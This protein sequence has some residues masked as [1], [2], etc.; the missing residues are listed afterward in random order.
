MTENKRAAACRNFAIRQGVGK[1][2]AFIDQ[3]DV[4]VKD[5]LKR[6]IDFINE[7]DYDAVHGNVNYIDRNGNNIMREECEQENESRRKIDWANLAKEELARRLLITPNIRIISSLIKREAFNRIGGFNDTFFGGE[8]EIFWF[9]MAKSFKIGF[10]DNTLFH[11]VIHEKNT[12]TIYSIQRMSGYIEALKQIKRK[13]NNKYF[14][15]DINLK[16]KQKYYSI[17]LTSL[18]M[19]KIFMFTKYFLIILFSD[20]VFLIEKI[21][22]SK[23]RK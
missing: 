8:D 4:W 16:L 7:T 21:N 18:K 20:P 10:L 22:N 12:S 14:S 17:L 1:Y 11:R 19:R 6:Q 3:D 23:A 9:E 5:K 13:N 15:N 2:I